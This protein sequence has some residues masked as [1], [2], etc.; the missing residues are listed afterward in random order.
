MPKL[1]LCVCVCVCERDQGN[2][3]CE[4][5]RDRGNIY[6]KKKKVHFQKA[7]EEEKI[8]VF[9]LIKIITSHTK[10]C[11]T[12]QSTTTPPGHNAMKFSAEV[13][14]AHVAAKVKGPEPAHID[15]CWH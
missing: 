14:A 2:S 13:S 7:K 1:D 12:T 5:E 11:Q 8:F 9:S 4:R 3:V 10:H 6:L 15:T